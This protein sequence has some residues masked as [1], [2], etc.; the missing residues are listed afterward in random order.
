LLTYLGNKHFF[1]VVVQLGEGL[2][3]IGNLAVRSDFHASQTDIFTGENSKGIL[4][5]VIVLHAEDAI[6]KTTL[7]LFKRLK[8]DLKFKAGVF[9]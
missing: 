3:G 1:G 2:V 6:H 4:Q 9:T 8:L 5:Q 7:K